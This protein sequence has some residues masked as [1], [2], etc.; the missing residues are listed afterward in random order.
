MQSLRN[1]MLEL[2]QALLELHNT[3]CCVFTRVCQSIA[4]L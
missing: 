2:N 3:T 4:C 1:F